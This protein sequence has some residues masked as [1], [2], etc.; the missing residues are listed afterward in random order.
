VVPV[1]YQFLL[2]LTPPNWL[3]TLERKF[4]SFDSLDDFDVSLSAEG[5]S[6]ICVHLKKLGPRVAMGVIKTW[7][8]A[9]V[10]SHRM[11]EPLLLPCIFGCPECRDELDHYLCCDPL[12]TAVISCSFKQ[13]ELLWSS[14]VSR[15]GLDGSVA[16]LQMITIAFSC[17][18]AIKMS[19]QGETLASLASGHLCQVHGRLMEYARVFASDIMVDS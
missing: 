10:T 7:A 11:H 9:W 14:P 6:V 17:Y 4:D 8:N 1:F 15:L 19:H 13:R 18:H 16:S 2:G 3:L 5:L 12:W